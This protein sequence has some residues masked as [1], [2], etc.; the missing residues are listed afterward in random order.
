MGHRNPFRLRDRPGTDWVYMGEV[1][2]DAGGDNPDRGPRRYEE[3]NIIKR[4]GNGGWPHCI[5]AEQR[6]PYRDYDFDTDDVGPAFDCAGGPTNNSPNNTGLTQLP[7][8]DSLPT[9]WYPYGNSARC[10]PSWAA[11]AAPRW[12]DR[13][14]ATT[15]NLQS[16]TKWPAY[17]DGTADLLRVDAHRTSR[18][19]SSTPTARC[20][21]STRCS[22]ASASPADGHGVRAGRLAV[23]G[24]VR[25]R[26]LT[27]GDRTSGCTGSTTS[28]AGTA[29]T[30][31]PTTDQDSGPAPL[32]VGFDASGSTRPGRR[33]R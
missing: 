4:A 8:V 5:G 10:S 6:R 25:R 13:S 2:P 11:A 1:G 24:R 33:R 16:E 27:V 31:V 17:S 9:I 7:P 22:R 20:R 21:R 26:L 23:R 28:R 30:A 3:L 29:P 12:A 15:P 18:T 19:S 14:T 32:T